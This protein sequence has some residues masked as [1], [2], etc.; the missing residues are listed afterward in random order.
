MLS[1]CAL[2]LI[3]LA[4]NAQQTFGT[5]HGRIVNEM[6]GEGMG[7]VHVV[8]WVADRSTYNEQMPYAVSQSDGSFR[9]ENVRPGGYRIGIHK[10]GFSV[11]NSIDALLVAVRPGE[12][13]GPMQI[14]LV[15]NGGVTGRV[16]DEADAAQSG[17]TVYALTRDRRFSVAEGN[18]SQGH[19]VTDAQGRYS[20]RSLPD[21]NYYLLAVP[22]TVATAKSEKPLAPAFYPDAAQAMDA[23]P[24]TVAAGQSV[25]ADIKL[26]RKARHAV[27]GS[28]AELP[29]GVSVKDVSLEMTPVDCPIAELRRRVPIRSNGR[30]AISDVVSGRY[31]LRLTRVNERRNRITLAR[32]EVAVEADDVRDVSLVCMLPVTA[33]AHALFENGASVPV[34][35]MVLMLHGKSAVYFERF[36]ADGTTSIHNLERGQYWIGLQGVPSGYYAASIRAMGQDAKDRPIDLTGAPTVDIEVTLRGGTGTIT[37]NAGS[38]PAIAVLVP[39]VLFPDR[40]SVRIE[41]VR[42]GLPVV[43]ANL[44]P[45]DYT[46]Y[47][48]AP[49]GYELWKDPDFL[50]AVKNRGT[51]VHLEENGSEQVQLSPVDPGVIKETAQRLGLSYE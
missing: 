5:I 18:P 42:Q 14:T 4:E 39:A 26:Q 48:S 17:V 12:A 34:S 50:A 25:S 19:A 23:I 16:I 6:T 21:G 7:Q 33:V 51:A 49:Y 47:S 15:P 30:F 29:P 32:E 8:A 37:A 27:E 35:A 22:G 45:G 46:L 43:F 28:I 1:A 36:G 38:F 20:L 41:S 3:P 11:R 10:Q 9:I 24:V 13:V 31:E 40:T 2:V 44:P